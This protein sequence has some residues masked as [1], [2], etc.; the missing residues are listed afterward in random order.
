MKFIVIAS[1]VLATT[2]CSTLPEQLQTSGERSVINLKADGRWIYNCR[3]SNDGKTLAWFSLQPTAV[4]KNMQGETV[5][6]IEAGPNFVHND[7]SIAE[8]L[9]K[10]S[11]AAPQAGALP[12]VLYTAT[13]EG[14]PGAFTSVTSIQQINT[15]GGAV[16]TS[17]CQNGDEIMS[18]QA[19]PFQA[20]YR[21]L[22]K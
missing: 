20:E 13:A 4:L 3:L 1:V 2:A 5:G 17:G 11:V 19:V 8:A 6:K 15:Q 21:L 16:P 14:K 10:T 9:L 12:W 7:G 22:A 18:E